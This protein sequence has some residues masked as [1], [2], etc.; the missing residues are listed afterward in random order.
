MGP[1]HHDA[2]SSWFSSLRPGNADATR[3]T[4]GTTG[5]IRT[6]IQA[7]TAGK[8]H[9]CHSGT[10][11]DGRETGSCATP[12]ADVT[13]GTPGTAAQAPRRP[14]AQAPSGGKPISRDT[15]PDRAA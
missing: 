14:G 9:P 2:P 4:T 5:T 11:A 15:A 6:A 7:L 13:P 8:P 10:G 3:R 12:E 1:D